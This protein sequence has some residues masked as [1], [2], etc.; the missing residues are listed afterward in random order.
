MLQYPAPIRDEAGEVCG[1]LVQLVL[2]GRVSMTSGTKGQTAVI[3]TGKDG[4]LSDRK[5]ENV[6]IVHDAPVPEPGDGEVL[7]RVA[8]R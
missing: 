8:F 4:L 6:K 7:V 5:E 1:I 2:L 3:V